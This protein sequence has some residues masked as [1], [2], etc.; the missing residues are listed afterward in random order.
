MIKLAVLIFAFGAVFLIEPRYTEAQKKTPSTKTPTTNSL[1]IISRTTDI[2]AAGQKSCKK[3]KTIDDSD[4]SDFNLMCGGA[5][6][7]NFYFWLDSETKKPRG[8]GYVR[9]AKLSDFYPLLAIG[10]SY[11]SEEDNDRV[12]AVNERQTSDATAYATNEYKARVG[13]KIEWF[14]RGGQTLAYAVHVFYFKDPDNIR[15]VLDPKTADAEFIFV[16]GVGDYE[17]FEHDVNDRTTSGNADENVRRLVR[18][19]FALKK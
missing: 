9:N 7:Y 19:Y 18:E 14:T 2:S 3:V 10:E 15:T 5:G 16:R 12:D 4:G 11:I 8:W 17:A 6:G 13:S 1:Q